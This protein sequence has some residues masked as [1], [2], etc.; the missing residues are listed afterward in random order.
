MTKITYNEAEILERAIYLRFGGFDRFSNIVK[1]DAGYGKL[2]FQINSS[3]GTVSIEDA[4][5]L[6]KETQE[7]IK[8]VNYLNEKEYE[9]TDYKLGITREERDKLAE[10]KIKELEEILQGELK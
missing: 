10:E 2:S 1:V 8:I 9:I 3:G 5:R 7:A 4:E 6:I